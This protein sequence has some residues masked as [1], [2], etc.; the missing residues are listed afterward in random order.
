[1]SH[2]DYEAEIAVIIGTGG[3]RI[4]ASA[5]WDHVAGYSCYN[6]GSVR[7]PSLDRGRADVRAAAAMSDLQIYLTVGIFATVIVAIAKKI[8]KI[9]KI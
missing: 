7:E 1:M 4:A 6:D 3:R 9:K 2:F 5:A 8:L